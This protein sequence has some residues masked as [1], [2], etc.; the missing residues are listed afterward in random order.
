VCM[1][2]IYA[3]SPCHR[4]LNS[5]NIG[6]SAEKASFQSRS[7]FVSTVGSSHSEKFQSQPEAHKIAP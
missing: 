6:K 2:E 4:R 5:L 1:S 7:V 3:V